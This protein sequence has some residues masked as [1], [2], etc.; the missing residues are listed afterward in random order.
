MC[1]IYEKTQADYNAFE[2]KISRLR[3]RIPAGCPIPALIRYAIKA[4]R[5]RFDHADYWADN[6]AGVHDCMRKYIFGQ[7]RGPSPRKTRGTSSLA[8]PASR[9]C[10]ESSSPDP[11]RGLLLFILSCWYNLQ[12]PADD[13]WTTHLAKHAKWIAGSSGRPRHY[14][15]ALVKPHQ[16]RTKRVAEACRGGIS[17]W[18]VETINA[19]A[20]QHGRRPGNLSRFVAKVGTDLYAAPPDLVNPL[21][22]G[23]LPDG[24]NGPHH[25]RLWMLIMLL[26]RD[27]SAVR[28]LFTSALSQHRSPRLNGRKALER[29]YDPSYFD[30]VECELPVDSR[31]ADAWNRMCARIN[32]PDLKRTTPSGIA[33]Q[34]RMLARRHG[35]SPSIFDTLLYC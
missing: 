13:V 4:D 33:R 6:T 1:K 12:L 20:E 7:C 35:Q 15:D 26:T 16:I 25:K 30:P 27:R 23:C 3:K 18:F 8:K 21:A 9:R 32:R 10:A 5:C 24:Y 19:I 31:V 14:R 17:Q 34:A 22:A 28:C 11:D 29:W 2:A